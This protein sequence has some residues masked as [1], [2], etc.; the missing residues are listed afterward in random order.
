VPA[1][2]S[3]SRALHGELVARVRAALPREA[4]GLLGGRP[5][6]VATLVVPLAN[7]VT[8]DRGFLADPYDQFRA[9]RRLEREGL[10]LLAIYHSHPGGS[11][12]P[13]PVDVRY[14]ARWSCAHLVVAVGRT[15][16]P[17]G[18]CRAFAVE[19]GRSVRTVEV[20]VE[21]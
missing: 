19:A 18:A 14:A 17:D 1:S 3:L 21:G 12:Q 8:G 15:D 2:L 4:V 13:S 20:A 5:D 7:L 6:G 11:L 9:L 10:A 16:L